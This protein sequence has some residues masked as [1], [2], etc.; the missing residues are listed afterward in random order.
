MAGA[1]QGLLMSYGRPG[2]Y[3]AE[4]MVVAGG[5]GRQGGT[6]GPGGG[7]GGALSGTFQLKAGVTYDLQVGAG[8]SGSSNGTNSY[9]SNA[10]ES[11]NILSYGGG[12]SNQDGGSGGGGLSTP[13]YGS[14]VPARDPGG[15]G[16]S[17]QGTNGE[18]GSKYYDFR[19]PGNPTYWRCNGD[20]QP[21][22][23]GAKNQASSITGA[24]VVYAPPSPTSTANG[25]ANTGQGAYGVRQSSAA[26]N[27]G[28]GVAVIAIPDAG[29]TLQVSVGLAHEVITTRGGYIV[30]R[31]TG[32]LGTFQL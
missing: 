9:L 15:L 29:A 13:G 30:Y 16:V 6:Y 19:C 25:T 27:G 20:E 17:G 5:G 10:A 14:P 7:A 1:I 28:S 26:Q 12:A 11:L 23:G 8:G 4:Y 31:F 22:K 21:A 24:A 32:G 3:V 18:L 2:S